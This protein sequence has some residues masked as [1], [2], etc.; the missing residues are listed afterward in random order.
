M[1][2]IIKEITVDVA[3]KNLFQ[4]IIAKQYDSLSRFLKVTLVNEGVGIVVEN[5]STV[6]INA[7]RADKQS[8]SFAGE[9]N[10]DGTVTVPLTSWMLELD[11]IVKCDIS[12]IDSDSR[13][14]TSTSFD[15]EVEEAAN[16][17][18]EISSDENYDI[19]VSLIGDVRDAIDSIPVTDLTYN[20][21][22]ENPQSGIAVEQAISQIKHKDGTITNKN[23]CYAEVGEWADGN[24]DNED[25]IGYF[26]AIDDTTAGTTMVKAGQ[27]SDVRG[28]T[29]ASPAFS[30]NCSKDKFNEDGSLK[31]QFNYVAN[32]GLVSVIDDG[33]CSI[34]GKCM[35]NDNGMATFDYYGY[36]VVDRIDENHIL[37]AL[38]PGA[39]TEK[40]LRSDIS[41]LDYQK[42]D[43]PQ[44][45]PTEEGQV[46]TAVYD[47]ELPG[48][49]TKWASVSSPSSSS[50]KTYN[51]SINPDIEGN[52]NLTHFEFDLATDESTMYEILSVSVRNYFEPI[53]CTVGLRDANT[54]GNP[55]QCYVTLDFAEPPTEYLYVTISYKE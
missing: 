29:V 42:L 5:S 2:S 22:S 51:G 11:G 18:E 21:E 43:N 12:I 1:A 48:F 49:N 30:V 40:W 23:H 15:I 31:Q 8:K 37:I 14:L 55:G 9:V 52:E 6:I 41:N 19:L 35:P 44:E 45:G 32:M 38:E 16:L 27:Y 47:A 24:P 20:H 54:S 46:L 36:H 13:K 7:E 53:L 3:K 17:N 10:E 50:V 33:S 28:V 26:V 4:A 25:R 39:D 34:N